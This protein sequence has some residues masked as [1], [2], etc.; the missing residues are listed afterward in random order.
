M[1]ICFSFLQK[2]QVFVRHAVD[3]CVLR[4]EN[5]SSFYLNSYWVKR[6]FFFAFYLCL[7]YEQLI[8]TERL[9]LLVRSYC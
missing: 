7:K 8:L 9:L 4:P 5:V 6:H 3:H 1:N 2:C